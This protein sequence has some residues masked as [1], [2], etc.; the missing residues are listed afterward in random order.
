LRDIGI[1]SPDRISGAMLPM[2]SVLPAV[3]FL[4]GRVR[5][6]LS[7][8]AAFAAGFLVVAMG[9][10]IDAS[11]R[12]FALV[13]VGQCILA[14][15]NGL[16]SPSV[17]ALAANTGAD[18]QKAS[19]MGYAR[20]GFVGGPMLGQL[21]IEPIVGRSNSSVGLWTLAA[22]AAALA[23]IH[24]WSARARPLPKSLDPR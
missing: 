13:V 8:T 21:M 9:L 17:F 16:L 22:V 24:G 2:V 3:A 20:A 14:A 7:L 15:G 12:T 5:N 23:I 19:M 11:A 18:T 10:A 4:Y 1:A 6:H